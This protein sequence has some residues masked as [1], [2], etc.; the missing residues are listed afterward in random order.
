MSD[1]ALF[2]LWLIPL[3]VIAV[4]G[5]LIVLNHRWQKKTEQE[6]KSVR[7]V[8]RQMRGE[9]RKVE[10][11]AQPYSGR[12]PEPYR[13]A[14]SDLRSK[15][16]AIRRKFEETER[17]LV[18][19][20]ERSAGL[21]ANRW[22][23][24]LGAPYQWRLLHRDTGQ[25]QRLLDHLQSELDL[26]AELQKNLE[27]IPWNTALELRGLC[28]QSEQV[29][30]VLAGLRDQGLHGDTFEAALHSESQLQAA[31]AQVNRL[32]LEA[33]ETELLQ[34][35]TKEEVALAYEVIQTCGPPLEA[36][37]QQS[38]LWQTGCESAAQETH[39]M[40]LALDDLAQTL[41]NLPTV[42]DM[43]EERAAQLQL[44]EIARNLQAASARMEVESLLLVAQEAE[45]LCQTAQQ[46]SQQTKRT[47]RELASFET[48]LNELAGDFRDLSLLLAEL[49]A[50]AVHPVDWDVSLE[51]LAQL[52][53]RANAL[54]NAHMPRTP[55]KVEQ[56]FNSAADIRTRQKELGHHIQEI[57]AAHT[58]LAMLLESPEFRAMPRWIQS[59]RALAEQAAEYAPE[60]WTSSV[61]ISALPAE[62]AA[63]TAEI[64]R[65]V[66]DNPGEPISELQLDARLAQIRSLSESYRGLSA[67]TET[68][69]ERLQEIQQSERQAQEGLENLQ[70]SLN[71][72]RLIAQSNPFLAG[73]AL[74]EI[75][76]TQ[77][78]AAEL[79]TTLNQ[80]QRGSIEKKARQV[81][82]GL[83]RL[84]T[85]SGRWLDQMTKEN[86]A[87]HKDLERSLAELDAIARLEDGSVAEA[88]RLL[89][90]GLPR[91]VS[92]A[93]SA[94]KLG[95]SNLILQLKRHSDH[96][97]ERRAAQNALE[98][99]QPLAETYREAVHQRKQVNDLASEIER[100]LQKRSWPPVSTSLERERQDL[101]RLDTEWESLRQ[102]SGKAISLVTQF[103]SLASRYQNLGERLRQS[104]DRQASEMRQV[105]DLE[106][107]IVALTEPWEA[108]LAQYRDNPIASR[109]I[110]GLLAD[111]DEEME[112]I[113]R[114]YLR[115]ELDYEEVV[116]Q[117]RGL[118]RRVRYYQVAL[119]DETALDAGGRQI[120][121]RQSERGSF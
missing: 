50:R 73:I 38:H 81:A 77:R 111:L 74:S 108:L 79:D 89:S 112:G 67:R 36:L 68:A 65:L 46:A 95:L 101:Q 100:S 121:R 83:E 103:V 61:N 102:R 54:G 107:E 113:E 66:T 62:I 94:G 2:A 116:Q 90:A 14:C 104:A 91:R 86:Q 5:G 49:G 29:S 39:K 15:L 71:Q 3:A 60:N 12:D 44:E 120:R 35:V 4:L 23:A 48:L 33:R 78:S 115:G 92:P 96:W 21:R 82:A 40:R 99:V 41:E 114:G 53:R 63:L 55:L 88:R 11:L 117:M 16:A 1:P 70:K 45:R 109:E 75:E 47:R 110:R 59:S 58:Q 56:D 57:Q 98:N 24:M 10:R 28:N 76:R 84:E 18:E 22:H 106:E 37:L 30:Q 93:P 7:Q 17:R 105:E 27:R 32:F 13:R 51:Q 43:T 19:L 119:D 6:L 69:R 9:Q 25:A 34:Q 8:L 87:M 118:Q 31:L 80:P 20:N 85:A 52:N 42:L 64:Q 97:Q 26:A 72:F